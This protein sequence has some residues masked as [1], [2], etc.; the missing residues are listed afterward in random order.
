MKSLENFK[1]YL[2]KS[3]TNIVSATK[4]LNSLDNKILFVIDQKKKYQ[5]TI[6]DGDVRRSIYKNFSPKNKVIKITNKKSTFFYIK[7]KKNI[8]KLCKTNPRFIAILNAKKEIVEIVDTYE[9]NQNLE[10]AALIMAGGQGKRLLPI[11]EK[12]PKPMVIVNGKPILE[13]LI[14][15]L[16]NFNISNIFIS[17]GYLHKK[18]ESYFQRGKNLNVFIRY[19][20]EKSPLGTAGCLKFFK[21]KN[22][23]DLLVINCDVTTNLNLIKLYEYHK[24]NKADFTAVVTREKK[25]IP[26]GIVVSNKNKILSIKEKPTIN[27]DYLSGIYVI[28]K[29]ILNKNYIKSKINM[30]EYILKLINKKKKIIMYMHEDYWVDLGTHDSLKNHII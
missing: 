25:K 10:L 23:K 15:S 30:N 4:K 26:F 19:I 20:I 8:K 7:Q 29:N 27:F 6:T 11:T 1:K 21:K 24:K 13:H 16:K 3:D 9:N 2:K 14:E 18:I 28:N 17:V 22:Y 12:I 5:G